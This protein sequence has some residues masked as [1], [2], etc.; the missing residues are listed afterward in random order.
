[1]ASFGNV[2]CSWLSLAVALRSGMGIAMW[3]L[4]LWVTLGMLLSLLVE[5]SGLM[6]G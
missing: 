5:L 1:M 3:F 6:S 2:R 4:L